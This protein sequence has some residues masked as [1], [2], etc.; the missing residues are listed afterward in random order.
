[1]IDLV[2]TAHS[3]ATQVETLLY[4]ICLDFSVM[5]FNIYSL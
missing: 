5:F 2:T 1:M 3:D 4:Y